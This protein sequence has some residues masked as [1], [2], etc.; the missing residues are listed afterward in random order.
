MAFIK[1]KTARQF[2]SVLLSDICT[3]FCEHGSFHLL[4]RAGFI[5]ISGH[6]SQY[7]GK[8]NNTYISITLDITHTYV[9]S[10]KFYWTEDDFKLSEDMIPHILHRDN[11]LPAILWYDGTQALWYGDGHA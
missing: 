8:I 1:V 11:N 10:K 7:L 3:P 4:N 5:N 6:G 2:I 9:I